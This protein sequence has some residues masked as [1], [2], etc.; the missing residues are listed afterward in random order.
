MKTMTLAHSDLANKLDTTKDKLKSF[1]QVHNTTKRNVG[2]RL[3]KM[4]LPSITS[5]SRV[6]L[7]AR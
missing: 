7:E 3:K 4:T 5:R 2:K 6:L 1:R